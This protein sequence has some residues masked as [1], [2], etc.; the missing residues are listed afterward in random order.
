MNFLRA[1]KF[2]ISR[3]SLEKIYFSY[4]RPLLEYSDTVWENCSAESKKLLEAIHTEAARIVSGA[5]KLRSIDKLFLRLGWEPLKSRRNTHKLLLFYKIIH[6][7]APKYL[8]ELILSLVQETTTYSVRNSDNIRN[9]RAHTNLFL[10][11]FFPSKRPVWN[12]LPSD[13]KSA[14]NME[15]SKI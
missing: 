15:L 13:L 11:S 12:D 8:S 3:K 10:N 6:G 4:I 9:Y 5:T 7:I 2:I 1:L 14:S